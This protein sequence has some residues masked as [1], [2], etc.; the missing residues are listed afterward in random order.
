MVNIQGKKFLNS[1]FLST[2]FLTLCRCLGWKVFCE[3]L[4]FKIDDN[5]VPS[6]N[7]LRKLSK[8]IRIGGTRIGTFPVEGRGGGKRKDASFS[9]DQSKVSSGISVADILL[10]VTMYLESK[11]NF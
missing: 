1:G 10:F 2:I 8:S 6:L 3:L 7:T 5:S 9:S 11:N 4:S